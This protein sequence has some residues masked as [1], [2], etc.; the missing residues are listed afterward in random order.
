MDMLQERDIA[1]ART[2]PYH[3]AS[4]YNSYL[5]CGD[6]L[7]CIGKKEGIIVVYENFDEV[8]TLF[9]VDPISGHIQMKGVNDMF[10]V[11][12]D[13][14]KLYNIPSAYDYKLHALL[15]ILVKEDESKRCVYH[16]QFYNRA[17][18]MRLKFLTSGIMKQNIYR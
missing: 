1:Q 14:R 16:V 11:N 9:V 13:N 4:K 7:E 5:L 17:E 8:K 12:S 6:L 18:L 3:A 2:S 15:V 10:V